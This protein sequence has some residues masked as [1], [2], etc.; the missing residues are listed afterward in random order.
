MFY[1]F[2]KRHEGNTK[3]HEGNLLFVS[4][5]DYCG[6][7]SQESGGQ[8]SGGSQTQFPKPTQRATNTDNKF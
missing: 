7:K 5:C 1:Y 8:E 6:K 4:F 2:T 3:R